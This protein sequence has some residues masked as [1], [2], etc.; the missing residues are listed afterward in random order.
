MTD[1]F[2][3]AA[4]V[5]SIG[6]FA[7]VVGEKTMKLRGLIKD[8][9]NLPDM[10]DKTLLK[11]DIVTNLLTTLDSICETD[12]AQYERIERLCKDVIQRLEVL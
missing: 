1:P 5:V 8:T 3:V 12:A 6:A 2:S 4:G 10:V 7:F 11:L 9:K